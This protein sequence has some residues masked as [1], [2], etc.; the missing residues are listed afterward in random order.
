MSTRLILA[1]LAMTLLLHAV[2]LPQTSPI[3]STRTDTAR[4][5][6]SFWSRWNIARLGAFTLVAGTLVYGA[7][8]WWVHDTRPFHFWNEGWMSDA[9][10]VDKIG[11]MYTSYFMFRAMHDMFSVG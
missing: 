1:T 10:G 2:A 4:V 5:D 8:V 6:H 3:D 7:G 11:H 9:N